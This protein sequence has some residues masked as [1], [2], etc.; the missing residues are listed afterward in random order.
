MSSFISR[1]IKKCSET[2][3]KYKRYKSNVR[4]IRG[5]VAE[6]DNTAIVKNSDIFVDSSSKL[7][8]KEKVRLEGVELFLTNGAIVEIN[9][10]SFFELNRNSVRPQYIINDGS[11]IVGD[12]TKLACQRVWIRYGGVCKIGNYTNII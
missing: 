3:W 8:L 7:I 6:I 10:Y 2:R 5:G 12:H 4:I 1:I 9:K 11:L